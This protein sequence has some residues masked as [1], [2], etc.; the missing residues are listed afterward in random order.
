MTSF[1]RKSLICHNF[2]IKFEK[3]ESLAFPALPECRIHMR[4]VKLSKTN[5]KVCSYYW[6][7]VDFYRYLY[8]NKMKFKCKRDLAA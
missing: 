2:L 6:L 8:Y 3:P 1:Q 5:C 4:Q 7:I